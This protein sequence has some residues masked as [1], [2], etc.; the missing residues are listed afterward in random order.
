MPTNPALTPVPPTRK[1]KPFFLGLAI[2]CGLGAIVLWL[3]WLGACA[4]LITPE[5]GV[6]EDSGGKGEVGALAFAIGLTVASVY[7]WANR[8]K[9]MK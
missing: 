3:A 2:L 6:G 5:M 9:A 7:F 1:P 4:N 8:Y